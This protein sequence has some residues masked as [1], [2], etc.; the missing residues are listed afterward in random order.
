MSPRRWALT[1]AALLACP[2]AVAGHEVRP[3]YLE[4]TEL[5][6]PAPRH[7]EILWKQPVIVDRAV[8]L[9]PRLSNG[10]LDGAPAAQQLGLNHL[11]RVW[12]PPGAGAD[13]E[14]VTITIDGL[15]RTITDVL[16]RVTLAD[17]RRLERFLTPAEP[18]LT[19][20]F[21]RTAV[22]APVYLQLGV[23]HILTGID[24]LAFVLLLL[25][26]IGGGR[27]LVAAVTAFTAAHSLTLALTT[28]GVIR[29]HAPAVEAVVALSIVFLA[30]ELVQAAGGRAGLTSRKPWL[31]PFAF[32]LLHGFAF[33]GALAEIGLPRGEIALSLLLFNLG[34]ELGQ[35]LFIAVV[36]AASWVVSRGARPMPG[37]MRLVPPYA[38]GA[39]AA[40]WFIERL[41]P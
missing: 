24:H 34:V 18:S 39:F 33:A 8:R 31:V 27:R 5:S 11:I 35:L 1:A 17:G 41:Q 30:V 21:E 3:A 28:L 40:S 26:L 10:W 38:V 12:R 6:E 32:G 29:V 16:V 25:I 36:L 14:G 15:E 2:A 9:V 19:V 7:L 37:W 13:L 20:S 23:E 4:I 22:A